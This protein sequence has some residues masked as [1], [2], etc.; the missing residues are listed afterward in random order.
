MWE[1]EKRIGS[2]QI[3]LSSHHHHCRYPI[4]DDEKR[5]KGG[6][7]IQCSNMRYSKKFCTICLHTIIFVTLIILRLSLLLK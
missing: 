2:E 4:G 5:K 7:I 6:Y 3:W 1:R